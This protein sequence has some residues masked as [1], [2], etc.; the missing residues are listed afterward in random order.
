MNSTL[1][2]QLG[3]PGVIHYLDD[4]LV[5]SKSFEEHVELVEQVLKLHLDHGLLVKASKSFLFR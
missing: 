1:V 2:D 4:I 5:H 3:L